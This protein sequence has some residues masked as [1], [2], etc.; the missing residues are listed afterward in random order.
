MR[1]KRGA[2]VVTLAVSTEDCTRER[3]EARP[4]LTAPCCRP[5]SPTSAPRAIAMRNTST[6]VPRLCLSE[7]LPALCKR[8]EMQLSPARGLRNL[9]NT[10]ETRRRSRERHPTLSR[11]ARCYGGIPGCVCGDALLRPWATALRTG[12]SYAFPAA[13]S[14]AANPVFISAFRGD[15]EKCGDLARKLRFLTTSRGYSPLS[16]IVQGTTFVCFCLYHPAES[17]RSINSF[18]LDCITQERASDQ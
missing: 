5:T 6:C 13:V 2:V 11:P 15:K 4:S 8:S 10:A 16:I 3:P 18:V 12:E 14:R 9:A 17:K 7:E 1:K